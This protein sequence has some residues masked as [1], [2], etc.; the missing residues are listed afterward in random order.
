MI[1]QYYK[2]G[3]CYRSFH[4]YGAFV[5]YPDTHDVAMERNVTTTMLRHNPDMV[6]H[7]HD[8]DVEETV[9]GNN[10]LDEYEQM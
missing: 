3:P 4:V 9:P 5:G 6:R 10:I 2:K 1:K 7:N 8:G